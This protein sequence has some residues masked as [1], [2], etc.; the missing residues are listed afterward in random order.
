MPISA[1]LFGGRRAT[2]VPLVTESLRLAARRL[3]RRQRRLGEDR[4][5]R[6]QGRRAA[7]RPVRDA[8]VLR[9]QH[10]RL[11]RPLARGRP[12]R[13]TRPSCRAST[14]STGSARTTTGK[15]VWPGFGENSRVLKWIVERLDGKAEGVETPIG[16]LPTKEALDTDGLDIS[17]D[18]PRLAAHRRQGGLAQEAALIPDALRAPSATTCPRSCGTSTRPWSPAWA[19]LGP[20]LAR[21]LGLSVGPRVERS[22]PFARVAARAGRTSTPPGAVSSLLRPAFSVARQAIRGREGAPGVTGSR[23]R[24]GR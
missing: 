21:T 15:F 2:A 9:L 14:T 12:A 8:A 7:P 24:R 20:G 18:G 16:L 11:L 13:R 23:P 19:E 1:I 4:R 10:G 5:R 6:G 22:R 3:P 17:D